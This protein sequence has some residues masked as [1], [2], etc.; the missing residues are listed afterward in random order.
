MIL[1]CSLDLRKSSVEAE[2]AVLIWFALLVGMRSSVEG[3]GCRGWFM[4]PIRR[5]FSSVI[6]STLK[7]AWGGAQGALFAASIRASSC[8]NCLSRMLCTSCLNCGNER[9]RKSNQTNT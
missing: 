2:S 9:K 4:L 6:R 5:I 3:T 8:G 7:K 1:T